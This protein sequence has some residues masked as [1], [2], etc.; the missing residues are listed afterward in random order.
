[1][2]WSIADAGL[3]KYKSSK[4]SSFP[5]GKKGCDSDPAKF[6]VHSLRLIQT[7]RKKL[8]KKIAGPSGNPTEK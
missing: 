3:R 5:G 6:S 4:M 1:V 2:G 7:K 8:L